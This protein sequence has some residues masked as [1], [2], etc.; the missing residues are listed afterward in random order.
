[1]PF[2]DRPG[3][4]LYYEVH[5]SGPAI[6]F[7]HGLGGGC[8]SWWQQ[9]PHFSARG[10]SC[11][12]FSHRGFAPSSVEAPVAPDTLVADFT[13]D[14]AALIDELGLPEV[15]LVAQSMGGWSCLE[16]TLARPERVRG[17]V[18]ADTT[19]TVA[20][21]IEPPAGES[22]RLFAL[23][24]HPAA[25]ERMAREQ[26][27]LHHLYRSLDALS[28]DLDK[29]AVRAGLGRARIRPPADVAA[30]PVPVLG[31]AGA[32]DVVIAPA[33]VRALVAALP[34]GR[35]V[36]V[37]EAGHSVYFE[38]PAAFNRAVEEFLGPR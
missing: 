12:V 34:D 37:P 4:R 31:I 33:A 23:G 16:F 17:L 19:G 15:R 3:A 26:P 11:V 13:G 30:L 27:E 21:G 20:T 35:Y 24:I 1:M 25:G 7:A 38:R 18:L 2:L 14:L 9:V 36:E 32:E 29:G 8:V 5:G 28:A 6:V 10:W 22:E